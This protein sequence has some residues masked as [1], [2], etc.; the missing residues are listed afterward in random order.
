MVVSVNLMSSPMVT[1]NW[2]RRIIPKSLGRGSRNIPSRKN[3]PDAGRILTQPPRQHRKR[4]GDVSS[5][6]KPRRD[7]FHESVGCYFFNRLLRVADDGLQ[8]RLQLLDDLFVRAV[9]FD[10]G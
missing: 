5:P 7:E 4:C 6:Y 3:N 2:S 10:I 9:Y 8:F 1:S